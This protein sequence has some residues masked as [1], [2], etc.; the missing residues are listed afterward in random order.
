MEWFNSF[1]PALKIYWAV[2]LIATLVFVIQMVISFFGGDIFDDTDVDL[3]SD[4]DVGGVSHFFSVRNLVNFLLGA[5][6]G[7]VCF[8]NSV[9]NKG[10]LIFIAVL[11]GIIFVAIFFG[12]VEILLKL[13]KD[14]T[15]RLEETIGKTAKVYLTIPEN[16]TGR[17]K[18][19]ISIRGS[20]HEIDAITAGEKLPN[21]AAVKV[22]KVID[23]QT[24]E[25]EN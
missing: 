4:G 1:E 8:Y 11:I 13:Q 25:V 19:Q 2:A 21:G 22:E 24:V 12:L 20:I 9:E 7:G 3:S 15:F 23:G 18:I 10:V 6:W 14:N 17:G 5:G 16:R